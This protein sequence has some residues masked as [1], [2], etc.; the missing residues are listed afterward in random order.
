MLRQGYRAASSLGPRRA[1]TA[2]AAHLRSLSLVR[3]A[4]RPALPVG[5]ALCRSQLPIRLLSTAPEPEALNANPKKRPKKKATAAN[6][7]WTNLGL[8]PGIA[9]KLA[10]NFPHIVA[11]TPAQKLF[12]LAV[13]AGEEVYLKDEMGRGKT[14]ALALAA[15][16]LG[17]KKTD[18]SR[19]NAKGSKNQRGT[20]VLVIVPTPFLAAQVTDLMTKLSPV[21]P[22]TIFTTL[23]PPPQETPTLE[24][25]PLPLSPVVVSTAKNLLP[26]KLVLPNLTHIFLDEPDTLTGPPPARNATQQQI[27]QL[28]LVRHPPPVVPVLNA[29]LGINSQDRFSLDFT[30]RR[31]E[32]KTIWTSATMSPDFKRLVR[33]RGWVKRGDGLVELDFTWGASEK[34]KAVRERFVGAVEE[35]EAEAREAQ[36]KAQEGQVQTEPSHYALVVDP[37]TGEIDPLQPTGTVPPPPTPAPAPGTT[38]APAPLSPYL[39]QS[40]ALL[41]ATSPPPRGTFS[42]VLPPETASLSGLG[43]ALEELGVPSMTVVPET[44]QLGLPFNPTLSSDENVQEDLSPMLLAPRSAVPGLHIPNLHTIYLLNG[45]DFSSLSP[46][47]RRSGAS[48]DRQVFY[49]VVAGRLGRLGTGVKGEDSRVV[50]L[51]LRG[52]EEEEKLQKMFFAVAGKDEKGENG[53]GGRR[54]LA[55]W[56]MEGM[57]R[58]IQ[59]EMGG[60]M[61]QWEEF[62]GEEGEWEEAESDDVPEEADAT[63]EEAGGSAETAQ[64]AAVKAEP[65]VV[66]AEIAPSEAAEAGA[67]EESKKEELPKV[68][69]EVVP[70]QEAQKEEH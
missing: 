17:M 42:L 38:P 8:S 59:E 33:N 69:P 68:I 52:G 41:H 15:L 2:L 7:A 53:E 18:S 32:V 57:E 39:I 24:R 50:S 64:E 43:D 25:K 1:P 58:M 5:S 37:E 26:Y 27:S 3:S 36:A 49:D 22:S 61:E 23:P 66:K 47:Q 14:L 55:E 10:E 28:A 65:E 9:Q 63:S 12:L 46:R 29:I 4:A 44:L 19:K 16:E 11:P 35:R 67:V 48:R 20:K 34:N 54:K 31:D 6:Q 30:N 51:V 70:A 13:L 40:L 45:L 60:E 21:D 56:D 62:E